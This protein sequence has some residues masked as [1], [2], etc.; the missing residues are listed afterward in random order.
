MNLYSPKILSLLI[1][2]LLSQVVDAQLSDKEV[3]KKCLNCPISV[4]LRS[5]PPH[6]T[7][8]RLPR[9]TF[10]PLPEYPISMRLIGASGRVSARLSVRGDGTVSGY[11]IIDSSAVPF[12]KAVESAVARWKYSSDKEDSPLAAAE[13]TYVFE[14]KIDLQ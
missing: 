4:S 7:N 6:A 3:D 9:P 13:F 2:L 8:N 11:S 5:V 1:F 14:F 12:A 10:E